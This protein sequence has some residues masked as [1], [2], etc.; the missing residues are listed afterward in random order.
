MTPIDRQQRFHDEWL[1]LVQPVEGLVFSTPVLVDA[2]IAPDVASE[3]TARFRALLAHDPDA[4]TW[5]ANLRRLLADFLGYDQPGMLVPR[6]QLTDSLRFYAEEGRQEVRPSLAIART[7]AACVPI[8]LLTSGREL[9]LI[10]APTAES[11]SH[12]TFR[13]ADMVEPAGR[14]ILAAFQKLQP[15]SPDDPGAPS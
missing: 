13:F 1:G 2:Q 6:E 11:T 3:L 15:S 9:R 4:R 5:S 10:Y 12:L 7:P 14:P 8:G